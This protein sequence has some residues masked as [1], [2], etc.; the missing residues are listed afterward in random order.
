MGE[1]ET[2]S[3]SEIDRQFRENV[4]GGISEL[5][6]GQQNVLTRVEKINGS[7]K[8]LYGRSEF[9]ARELINHVG[10][11]VLKERVSRIDLMLATIPSGHE[12]NA[13]I[14]NFEKSICEKVDD[15]ALQVTKQTVKKEAESSVKSKIWNIVQP[16]VWVIAASFMTLVLMHAKDLLSK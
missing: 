2:R 15:L 14:D 1:D 5:K 13:K 8:E 6:S 3:N 11:C 7:I 12:I 10:T 4:I 16:L 9:N